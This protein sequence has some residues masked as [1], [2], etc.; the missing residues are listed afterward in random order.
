MAFF[1]TVPHIGYTYPELMIAESRLSRDDNGMLNEKQKKS[2]RGLAHTRKPVVMVGSAGLTD[3]VLAALDEALLRHELVK[4]KVS[5]GDREERDRAITSMTAHAKAE[6]IQ[7][8]GNMAVFYRRNPEE[9]VINL[10]AL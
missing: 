9:A 7:R 3:N 8:I 6:L 10:N 1:I 4:V 2:L 5:V